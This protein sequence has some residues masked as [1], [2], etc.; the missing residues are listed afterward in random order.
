MEK[1]ARRNSDPADSAVFFSSS[2]R[3][4]VTHQALCHFFVLRF[5]K[6]LI[7]KAHLAND[8]GLARTFHGSGTAARLIS[9]RSL[10]VVAQFGENGG[11]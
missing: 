7:V 6:D 5:E 10:S 9:I 11:T 3:R 1:I 4:S 2:M 8:L